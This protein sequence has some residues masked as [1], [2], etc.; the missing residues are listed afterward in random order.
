MTTSPSRETVRSRA[1]ILGATGAVGQRFVELL[2]QHPWFEIARLCGSERSA[3]KPYGEACR[4]RLASPLPEPVAALPVFGAEPEEGID[5]A[6]SALDAGVAGP[7]E[8]AWARAGVAVFSNARNH[9]LAPDVPLLVPE[10][11]ASHLSLVE[12]QRAGRGFSRGFIVTNPNCSTTFLAMAL[13]PLASAFGL[14]RVSVVTLQAISGA[15]YPGLPSLDILGNVIPFIEGEEEKIETET[16]KI[17]G[18]CEGGNVELARFSLSA[19]VNRVPVQDGHTEAVSF[20][21]ARDAGLEELRRVLSGFSGDPQRLGLPSA[22]ARPLV[23]FAE[24]D[25]PQP[26]L[27]LYREG[28]MATLV[29]RLRPCPVLGYRMTLL[30]HNTIRGAAGGSILNAELARARCLLGGR[31]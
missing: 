4:W 7:I 10:V 6:F 26:A 22:P 31:R 28:A 19:Q 17:L 2:S 18:T 11:N 25:R 23:L 3:G 14:R 13:A 21:L 5:L 27:D 16:L 24:R 20:E 8:E 30:G 15:G 29:G 12:R 1:A 9:R